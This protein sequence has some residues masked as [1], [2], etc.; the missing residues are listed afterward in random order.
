MLGSTCFKCGFCVLMACAAITV[1]NFSAVGKSQGLMNLVTFD[2]VFEFLVFDMW[3]V[4]VQAVRSVTMFVMTE[5][6][7]YFCM[8][9]W[10]RINFCDN[11]CMARVAGSFNIITQGNFKRLMRVGMTA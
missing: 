10:S 7:V 3:L 5:R 4:A 11:I 8:R 1:G 9:T 2:A 6:T